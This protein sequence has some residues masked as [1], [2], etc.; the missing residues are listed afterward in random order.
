MTD[1]E[2]ELLKY[3]TGKFVRGTKAETPERVAACTLILESFPDKLRA[4]VRDMDEEQLDTPYRPSGWTVRQLVHH[5]A[6]SHGQTLQR[7]KLALTEELPTIKPYKEALWA[8]HI[9]ARTMPLEPSLQ[10]ITGTHA[11]WVVLLRNM[12]SADFARAF[13]HPEQQR[14]VSLS[15]AIE[16]Y[17]WHSGHHL[18]HITRL[19]ER[20]GW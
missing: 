19:K 16:L 5:I 1:Q 8:E 17:V 13:F 20:S 4:E 11:R 10:I 14:E 6:D 9:D 7:F 3:P 15:E 12:S 18:A 2:L